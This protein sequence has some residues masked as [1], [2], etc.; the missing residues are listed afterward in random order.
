MITREEKAKEIASLSEKFGKAKA[1]FLVDFKG[2]SVEQVTSFRKKLVTVESEMK[3]V[4]NTLAIR[5]LADHPKSEPAI[6]DSF[7]GNNAVIFAY[8]DASASA[9]AIADFAKDVELLQI[10]VGV[11]DG[12]KLDAN[13]I[14]ALASL[15]SKDVLRAMLL[16]TLQ[17]PMSKFVGTLNAV[18]SGFV[19][20]LAAQKDKLGA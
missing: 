18:P 4:R 3:V 17:A 6:K 9:K 11:M 5:A 2:M 13:G 1:A 16:G 12:S 8:S 7:V 20:V 19:R 14:K 10:K 15:P